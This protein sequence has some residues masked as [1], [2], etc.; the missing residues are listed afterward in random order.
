MTLAEMVLRVSQRLNEAP[1]A[2]GPTFYPVTEITAALNE[3]DRMFCLLT[4]ALEKTVLWTA[5]AA[6]AITRMLLAFPDWMVPLRL[7]NEFGA[8][9]RP[10]R[11]HDLWALD[12]QWPIAAGDPIRYATAGSNLLALYPQPVA[13][14]DIFVTYVRSPLGLVL[15]ADT[16]ETP[17]EYHPA[18]IPYAIYRL[19]QVEG[20]EPFAA[21]LPLFATFLDAATE[22]NVFMRTRNIGAGYDAVPMEL[23]L[24]DRS[25]LIGLSK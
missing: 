23:K 17:T 2:G 11:L 10:C 3:A 18:Y 7:A 24:Y 1:A 13:P 8:P 25:A 21:S 16:P 14:Q 20:G 19:R 9:I 5:P 6:T 12:S 15:D 22:Y 4:L